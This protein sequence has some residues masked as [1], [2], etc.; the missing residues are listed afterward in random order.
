MPLWM[1]QLNI[2]VGWI[3][4]HQ[5]ALWFNTL[6]TWGAGSCVAFFRAGAIGPASKPAAKRL[7]SCTHPFLPDKDNP[8]FPLLSDYRPCKGL[9]KR[10][11]PVFLWCERVR[12]YEL[13]CG[14][15]GGPTSRLPGPY[16]FSPQHQHV[17]A[18]P[19]PG[20]TPAV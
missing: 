13:L 14:L 3:L 17:C 12:V 9:Q 16:G 6:L 10:G 18:G 20:R 19:G 7:G 11:A 1:E 2:V 15:R 8:G 4:I 5:K